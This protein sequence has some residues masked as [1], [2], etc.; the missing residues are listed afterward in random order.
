MV[1]PRIM[2]QLIYYLEQYF[3]PVSQVHD[4]IVFPANLAKL[5][6]ILLIED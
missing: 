2:N 1:K 6:K 5:T 3:P 4:G